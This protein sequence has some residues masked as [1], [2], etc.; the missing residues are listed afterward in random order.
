MN[1]KVI[2]LTLS[3]ALFVLWSFAQAQQAGRIYRIGVLF[4]GSRNQPH[5]E[6]FLRGMRELGYV[7]GKNIVFEYRYAEGKFD[8][9]R[10]LATELVSLKVDV[11]VTTISGS[12]HAV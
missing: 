9:L 5:L 7:E 11:I 8:R 1:K 3:A 2:V 10:E 6:S 4:F 12:A